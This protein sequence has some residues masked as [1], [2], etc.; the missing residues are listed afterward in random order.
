MIILI[1]FSD[2]EAD[3][4]KPT[5]IHVIVVKPL[6]GKKL[7]FT[8]MWAFEDWVKSNKITKWVFHNGLGYDVPV[9][10]KLVAPGLI[11]PKDVIDTAVIS[12]TVNYNKF[13]THSLDELG[14]FLKVYKGSYT[15]SWGVC[16]PDMIEYCEQDVEVLEAIFNH[17]KKY[18][19]DPA[20]AKAMRVEHDIAILCEEISEEGFP[21]N[22]AKATSYLE[23]IKKDM[24][25]LEEG[26][27]KDFPPTLVEKTRIQMRKKK[28]GSLYSNVQDAIDKY[29]STFVDADGMLVCL[30]YEEFNPGSP[31]QRIDKLWD[32]GWKP[33]DK[34]DGHKKFLKEK[35]VWKK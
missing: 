8:C 9:I 21:F 7:T 22:R 17:Y 5:K 1:V 3:G 30:D 15:G 19:Y 29:P 32:A 35:R 14:K 4:L 2:I 12:R 23:D 20:W 13:I 33:V 31:K 24:K 11:D 28:D 16:N 10:N 26:M 27:A 18:I 34:T 25:E 6:G